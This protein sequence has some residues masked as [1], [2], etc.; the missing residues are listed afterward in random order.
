MQHTKLAAPPKSR[1][2]GCSSLLDF[3]V[4][5]YTN[6]SDK[7]EQRRRQRR[8]E[9][10]GYPKEFVFDDPG[11]LKEYFSGEKI[12]C[13]R[14]GKSYR[15][16]GVH[17]KTIHGM[18]PDEYRM[19]YG[20]PWTYGLS[21]SE[22]KELHANFAKEMIEAGIFVPSLEQAEIA[23]GHLDRQKDRQPIRDAYTQANLEKMNE[24][25]TGEDAERRKQALKRGTQ[26]Y[27]EM[28]R[29][30]PQTKTFGKRMAKYWKGRKQTDDHVF[31]RTGHHKKI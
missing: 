17:L 22:T 24:G 29:N 27:R 5:E 25:K 20:I 30:R 9:L 18:E 26:E 1:A 31:K 8:K 2:V 3:F 11:K 16:L 15:T 19:I 4:Y 28:L 6:M 12:I 23:R 7:Q 10:P 21:C 14:C 13:L